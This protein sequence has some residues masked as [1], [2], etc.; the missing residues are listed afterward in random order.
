MGS[1]SPY[2]TRVPSD[3]KLIIGNVRKALAAITL[4]LNQEEPFPQLGEQLRE[5]G[6]KCDE[7]IASLRVALKSIR[8]CT[9]AKSREG[10][11]EA[12]KVDGTLVS[13]TRT[14]L[15]SPI[16][17]RTGCLQDRNVDC[18][19][20]RMLRSVWQV[21]LDCMQNLKRVYK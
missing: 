21:P 10:T 20:H 15:I 6:Q 7:A 4:A 14:D 3:V 9:T 16:T 18:F 17:I 2:N 13:G 19:D 1:S 12:T 11:F 8:D 5:L